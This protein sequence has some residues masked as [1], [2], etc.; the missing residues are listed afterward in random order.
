M[1]LYIFDLDGTLSQSDPD[2]IKFCTTHPVDWDHYFEHIAPTQVDYVIEPTARIFRA[3]KTNPENILLVVTARDERMKTKT[4]D[5]LKEKDL[6]PHD[7]F[8]RKLH[9]RR[10][11]HVIKEELLSTIVMK[12]GRKPLMAFEDRPSVLEMWKRNGIYTFDV[13]QGFHF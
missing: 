4:L 10:E 2:T 9:D 7:F 5:W 3:L 6:F 8:C 12:Y 1:T 13:S 11:D